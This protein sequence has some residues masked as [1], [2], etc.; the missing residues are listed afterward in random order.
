MVP[1]TSRS[2]PVAGPCSSFEERSV[3]ST[4]SAVDLESGAEAPVLELP[5]EVDVRDFDLSPDGSELILE[6][7]K[8]NS[9]LGTD[10]ASAALTLGLPRGGHGPQSGVL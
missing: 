3:T 9:D 6:Q 2:S 7:V 8:D 5:A 4:S 10:R 1:A